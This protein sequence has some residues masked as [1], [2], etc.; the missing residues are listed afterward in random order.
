[1]DTLRKRTVQV[2]RG[3]TYTFYVFPALSGKQTIFLLHGWP[4]HAEM[5]EDLA[6]KYLVPAGYGIIVP[7]CLGYGGSSKPINPEAYN[8]VGLTDDFIEILDE[9][10]VN[11]VIICGHDWG[12]GLAQRFHAFHPK[13]CS[14][15][16]T[17]SMPV[18]PP[19]EGPIVLDQL[20]QMMIKS[21]GYFTSWY[22]YLF[23]DPIA[24]PA[25]LDQHIE[26][27]FT[28]L[29][30]EPAAWMDTFCAED[31]LKKWLE[32]DRKGT[33]QSYATD[34][35]RKDFIQR[36]SQ[37][38]FAAPLCYYRALVTGIFYEQTKH[39]PVERYIIRVPYLFVASMLDVVCLPQGF[40]TA[41]DLGL[42]PNLTVEEVD[43]G[44]WC[45]LAQPK[46]VGEI[47]LKWLRE[48]Y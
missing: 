35:M 15:L 18:S 47:L 17:L 8:P 2:S 28:A 22:W 46:K 21:A 32:Q 45:M 40:K 43:A 19:P 44:H 30:A 3:F 5:W 48:N 38:G 25:L 34:A 31:G 27:L 6:V 11:E 4:D 1:M 41:E 7:D 29:H 20:A 24:G 33:V 23:S 42:T 14:G 13:R 12:A 9:E 16:I 26:S 10:R 36:M 37:D 39:L